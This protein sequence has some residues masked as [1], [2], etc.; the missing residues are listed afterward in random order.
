MVRADCKLEVV[1][2]KGAPLI[3]AYQRWL[4]RSL[5]MAYGV[6]YAVV[7]SWTLVK[8]ISVAG[9]A[10]L[11]VFTL[12]EPVETIDLVALTDGDGLAWKLFITAA[13]ACIGMVLEG[14]LAFAID[15]CFK[16]ARGDLSRP[17]VHFG[18]S[19]RTGDREAGVE[20]SRRGCDHKHPP[21]T[22]EAC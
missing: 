17:V 3:S 2:Q 9:W 22:S 11:T 4:W 13:L 19:A 16:R 14:Q 6:S 10:L 21:R 7:V 5:A 15:A 12:L 20:G 1:E 18:L 8:L